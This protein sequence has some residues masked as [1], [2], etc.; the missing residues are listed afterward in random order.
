M[1]AASVKDAI[2]LDPKEINDPVEIHFGSND[3]IQGVAKKIAYQRKKHGYLV[4]IDC[5]LDSQAF[6]GITYDHAKEE[7]NI[8]VS[9]FDL[10]E[11]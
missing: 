2:I 6:S 1:S 7:K 8:N 10:M 3:P 11:F 9:R 5:I 4:Y